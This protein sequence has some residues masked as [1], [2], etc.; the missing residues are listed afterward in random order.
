MYAKLFDGVLIS[1]PATIKD[2][3]EVNGVKKAFKFYTPSDAQYRKAGYLPVI[4]A[5]YPETDMENPKHYTLSYTERDGAIYGE[6]V[7]S[8]PPIVPPTIE[9]RTSALEEEVDGLNEALD[10]ILEGVTE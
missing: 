3:I 5:D 9:E 1:A 10:M 2:E 4:T 6:W 8:E 7:E